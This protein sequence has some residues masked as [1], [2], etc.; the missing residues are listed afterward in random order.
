MSFWLHHLG[1]CAPPRA[2]VPWCVYVLG[3]Q[4]VVET[5]ELYCSRSRSWKPHTEGSAVRKSLCC[6]SP[7]ACEHITPISAIVFTRG[8][9]HAGL[10][11][12]NKDT[13][14]IGLGAH[15]PLVC[16]HLS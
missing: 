11:L 16:P 7:L 13:S 6:A 15:P 3:L 14:Y 9:P 10:S 8:S 2:S 4:T 12:H 5:T 1:S